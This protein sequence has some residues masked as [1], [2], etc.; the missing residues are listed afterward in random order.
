VA[1]LRIVAGDKTIEVSPL[2]RVLFEREVL[3]R[4]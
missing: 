2:E 1:V 4:A 3:V